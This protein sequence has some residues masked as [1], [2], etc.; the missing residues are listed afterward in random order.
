MHLNSH[1]LIYIKL[2]PSD[3]SVYRAMAMNAAVMKYITGKALNV[4]EA[5][6]RLNNML[7]INKQIPELGFYKVYQ[8]KAGNF[9]GLG[10]LVFIKE[11]TAEI[12]YSLLPEYWGKK[13]ASEIAEFFIKYAQTF[14]YIKELIAIVNPENSASKKLLS[15][16]NFLWHETGFLNQQATEIHKLQLQKAS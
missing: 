10:K 9:I 6:D 13:Y 14:P 12:G 7:N 5:T 15:N 2:E 16:F 8:K 4:K 11:T 3:E 1:R